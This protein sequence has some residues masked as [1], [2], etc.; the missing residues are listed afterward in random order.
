M[1]WL[2]QHPLAQTGASLAALVLLAWLADLIARRVLLRLVI[3]LA[4]RSETAYDD[5]VIDRR[6][7]HR[8]AQ[9]APAAVLQLGIGLVPG[10]PLIVD[11]LVRNLAMGYMILMAMLAVSGSLAA[12][13]DIYH[14]D[15]ERRQRSI[16]GYLQVARLVVVIVGAILIVAVLI[17]RSPLLLFTG[18]GAMGAVLLLVFKDTLLSLVASVQLASNDIIRVGDWVELPALGVDG[19]VIDIALHTVKVRNFDRTVSTIPTSRFITDAVKNWRGM[20]ESGGRRIKRALNIDLQTVRFLDAEDV[21]RLH[22]FRLLRDYL[23]GK[24][25]ELDQFNKSLGDDG[26]LP[27]NARRLTNLGSFRAYLTAYLRARTDIRSDM[28]L[29]VRQLSPAAQGVPLELYCFTATTAWAEYEGIMAD[30]FDHLIAILPEF[31]LRAFQDPGGPELA[32]LVAGR[33]QAGAADPAAGG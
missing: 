25:A 1:E 20:S 10:L 30:I 4:R 7:P 24:Q 28:T 16:K 11:T 13:G 31:G 33:T 15:P 12:V 19:D 32:A 5:A 26:G 18:L 14:R 3:R 2:Q 9:V 8:V 27:V 17:D 6:V 29:M 23:A 21:Q 22:R